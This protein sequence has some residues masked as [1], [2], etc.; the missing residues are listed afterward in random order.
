MALV[1]LTTAGVLALS[2]ASASASAADLMAAA[3]SGQMQTQA[4]PANPTTPYPYTYSYNRLPGPKASSSGWIPPSNPPQAST[5]PYQN[6]P[7]YSR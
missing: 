1:K 4:A 5:Y 6:G 2:L 3:P 7:V